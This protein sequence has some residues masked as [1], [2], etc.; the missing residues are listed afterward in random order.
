MR[1]FIPYLAPEQLL[2]YGA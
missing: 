1:I 2:Y